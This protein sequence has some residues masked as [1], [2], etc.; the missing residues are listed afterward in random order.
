MNQQPPLALL[1]IFL[2]SGT[3]LFGA[4]A[5]F[6]GSQVT[7]SSAASEGPLG[8]AF[9]VLF[10]V[11]LAVV[12]L[13]KGKVATAEEPRASTYTLVG[14]AAAESPALF[15]ATFL[16]MH[17]KPLFFLIGSTFFVATLYFILPIISK[18]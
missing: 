6:L 17:G 5:W 11:A 4:V 18:D 1:R 8:V 9:M 12:L 16:L 2:L 7:N 3:V 10:V 15:G 13:F 14:W